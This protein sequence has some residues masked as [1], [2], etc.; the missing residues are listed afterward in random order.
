M[1]RTLRYRNYTGSTLY[2]TED[3][4][5]HGKIIGISDFVLYEGV[6]HAKLEENFRLAVDEYLSFCAIEG[7]A[8]NCP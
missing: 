6:D 3:K 8:P 4:L 1:N 2:S 5:F 7:K